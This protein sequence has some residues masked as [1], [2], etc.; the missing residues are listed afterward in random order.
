MRQSGES[1]GAQ[2]GRLRDRNDGLPLGNDVKWL[3]GG[4]VEKS[5]EAEGGG[6]I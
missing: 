1:G 4:Q 2:V 5:R 6:G 3:G